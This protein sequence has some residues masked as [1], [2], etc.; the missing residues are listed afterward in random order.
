MRLAKKHNNLAQ[1][2]KEKHCRVIVS[3]Y[4]QKIEHFIKVSHGRSITESLEKFY[5]RAYYHCI[6]TNVTMDYLLM[7]NKLSAEFLNGKTLN[8][9]A[10]K[11]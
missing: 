3:D 1:I 9:K 10:S 2:D 8:L 7:E 5:H 6:P 11:L 4:N